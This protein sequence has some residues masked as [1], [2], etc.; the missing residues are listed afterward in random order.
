MML[1]DKPI[2]KIFHIA[3]VHIK[4]LKYH[5][6]YRYIFNKLY[7]YIDNNKTENSIIVL[8]GDILHSK[9]QLSPEAVLLTT[10]FCNLSREIE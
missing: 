4:L 3:D 1:I 6:E 5:Y 8:A 10:E 2:D 7:Q 9:L